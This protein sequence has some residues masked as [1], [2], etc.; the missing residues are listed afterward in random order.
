MVS[1]SEI[2]DLGDHKFTNEDID[3]L[4]IK[5]NNTNTH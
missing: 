2:N 3:R 4:K 1:L 5:M